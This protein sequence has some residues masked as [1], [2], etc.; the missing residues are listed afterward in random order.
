MSV[1]ARGSTQ[2][3]I[4]KDRIICAEGGGTNSKFVRCAA[5]RKWYSPRNS[6]SMQGLYFF[7]IPISTRSGTQSSRFVIMPTAAHHFFGGLGFFGFLGFLG[8]FPFFFLDSA[9]RTLRFANSSRIWSSTRA[10]S[11]AST[12]GKT[13]FRASSTSCRWSKLLLSSR[14]SHIFVYWSICSTNCRTT[15]LGPTS[16]ASCSGSSAPLP[17]LPPL[18]LA[19]LPFLP[20]SSLPLPSF[21]FSLG[22]SSGS[23][24]KRW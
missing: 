13:D 11:S 3:S 4:S 1:C 18:P 10:R 16:T 7:R 23:L 21:P 17:F 8:F 6:F 9:K 24:S 5:P 2:C 12:M 22:S 14:F 20:L 19:S 15:A